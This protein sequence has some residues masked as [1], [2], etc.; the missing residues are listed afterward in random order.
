MKQR[1]V[2]YPFYR[3]ATG[4]AEPI[5]AGLGLVEVLICVVCLV[6][7]L[8]IALPW[9][10]TARDT[11]REK[12]CLT[13]SKTIVDGMIAYT[14]INSE[15]LPYLADELSW[16]AQISPFLDLPGAVR[17][18]TLLSEEELK[19]LNVPQFVCPADPRRN[20]GIGALSYVVN[21]GYGQFPVDEET[22]GVKQTGM[23]SPGLDW[24][25][26]GEVTDRDWGIGYA[27]GVVWP[28]DPRPDE[29]AFRMSLPYISAGDGLEFTLLLSENLDAGH[30]LSKETRDLAFVIGKERFHFA[31]PPESS[32]PLDFTSV[33][34]GPFAI[35]ANL[36]TLPGQSPA[37][38]SLHGDY[39]H[40][41]YADGHGGPISAKIDPRAYAQLMTPAGSRYGQ[42]ENTPILP[43]QEE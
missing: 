34:L 18:G 35:N 21:S 28:P 1:P 40:A 41:M 9:L 25:G 11:S 23:H 5:R 22:A 37:P 8:A 10:L 36:G 32:G 24:D 20:E 43:A 15:Q 7:L 19:D 17:D 26:D 27:T 30:W 33:D 16:P 39:V 6:L 2:T 3:D 31:E 14:D 4:R 29:E 13:R 38:S 12:L 42:G